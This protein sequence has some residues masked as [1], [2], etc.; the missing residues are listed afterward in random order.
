M[1]NERLKIKRVEHGGPSEYSTLR[2]HN[3]GPTPQPEPP[4]K[5]ASHDIVHFIEEEL[6]ELQSD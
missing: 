4:E 1:R 6:Y 3:L 5:M 2:C